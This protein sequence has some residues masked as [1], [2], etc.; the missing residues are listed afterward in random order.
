VSGVRFPAGYRL[1]VLGRAHP[2]RGFRSGEQKVDDWLATKAL[3]HQEKRLSVTKVLLDEA[4]A[5]A[6]YYTLTTGQ[7]DFG[8]LPQELA[9]GLP[10][11]FLPVVVLAWFGVGLDRQGQ[12]L[13][14]SLLAQALGD[15]YHAGKTLAFIAVVVDCLSDKAKT[16]YLR[17][18][19]RELPGHP[20]RLFLSAK[21]LEAM[22]AGS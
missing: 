11:R 19:F 7:L 12:G 2:R 13:G 8:D 22:M 10:R 9:K 14:R 4:G 1:E 6:G 20:Y 18:D 16:F 3:Q 21:R 5:I 17:W 15:C